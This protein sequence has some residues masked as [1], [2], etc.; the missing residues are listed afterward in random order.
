MAA[1]IIV[2]G[3]EKG[4]SGKSTN[5]MHVTTALVRMGF[6]VGALDLDLR[7]KSFSRYCDN[8][9]RFSQKNDLD[10]KWPEV[11]ALPDVDRASL[12]PGE[13]I[14]DRRLSE[15]VAGMEGRFDFIVIDCPGSHTRLSQVAHSLADTLV[16]PLNDSFIDFDLLARMDPETQEILG[17]SVYSEMVWQ[18]RQLRAQAGLTPIDWIV[19]R[20]R[21][22]TQRMHNKRK[23]TDAVERLASRIGFRVAPGF[24]ERVIFRELFPRGLT[25]LDLSEIGVKNLNISNVAARQELRDLM[26]ALNLPG[27]NVNF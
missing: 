18:A 11:V 22:G 8:R 20:N 19:V 26:K 3:N 12:A 2:F 15:A 10:L 21:V 17:P 27:V 13:N 4:G 1:H 25:L 24:S 9:K 5:C 23:I 14:Y 16:T 6:T 7:Q